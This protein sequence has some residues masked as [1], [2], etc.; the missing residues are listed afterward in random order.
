MTSFALSKII[1]T[2][3]LGGYQIVASDYSQLLLFDQE[4]NP[5]PTD[6]AKL[7][8]GV[9]LVVGT[10]PSLQEAGRQM[11]EEIERDRQLEESL[12]AKQE[13]KMEELAKYEVFATPASCGGPEE[14]KKT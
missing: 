13:E 12:R 9:S 2:T 7:S 5:I 3:K 8:Y 14:T 4:A 1:T 10:Y 11:L 6:R